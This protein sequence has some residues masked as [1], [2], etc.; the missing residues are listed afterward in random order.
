MPTQKTIE[1]EL[2]DMK[3]HTTRVFEMGVTNAP[4]TEVIVTRVPTGWIYEGFGRSMV[5]FVPLTTYTNPN[6]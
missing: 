5:V 4:K 6:I 3:V 2:Y 1:Q